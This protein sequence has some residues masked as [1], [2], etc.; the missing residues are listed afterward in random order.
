MKIVHQLIDYFI[1]TGQL[2]KPQIRKLEK[3]GFW[4]TDAP[5][6]ARHL[7][8][9]I[10]AKFYFLVTGDT[11]GPVWGTDIYTSDSSLGTAAVHAG[12]L[13][14]GEKRVLQLSIEQPLNT[15]PGTVRHGITSGSWPHWPGAF[16]LALLS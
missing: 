8:H 12:L 16:S 11:T 5:H 14:P 7:E 13:T 9:E 2:S 1:Q 6:N 15:Y 10:G 3:K 4:A